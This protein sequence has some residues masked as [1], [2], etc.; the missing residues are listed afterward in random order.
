[1]TYGAEKQDLLL[2]DVTLGSSLDPEDFLRKAAEE[3]DAKIGQEWEL[4][5]PALP[6]EIATLLRVTQAHIATGRILLAQPMNAGTEDMN[7][8]GASLV[9]RALADLG[10]WIDSQP[11]IDGATRVRAGDATGPTITNSENR[12][13]FDVFDQFTSGQSMPVPWYPGQTDG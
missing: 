1:M 3:M 8:Y 5:L 12:S 13:G 6:V 4:P 9:T 10:S 11:D 2:G 7:R